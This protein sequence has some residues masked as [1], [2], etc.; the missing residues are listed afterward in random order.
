MAVL[1]FVEDIPLQENHPSWD[2][3]VQVEEGLERLQKKPM[4]I[5]W[6]GQDFCFNDVF[7][8]EWQQRFPR[9]QSHY[10]AEA[11]HYLLEDALEPV[12]AKIEGF[13]SDK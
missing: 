6:G 8:E 5:C 11:G 7:F 4:L 10:F 2:T 13:L 9:A 1:R 12:R 3:L